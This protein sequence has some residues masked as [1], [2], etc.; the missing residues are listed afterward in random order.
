MTDLLRQ[1]AYARPGSDSRREAQCQFDDL[2]LY[3]WN[4]RKPDHVFRLGQD[5]DL[6]QARQLMPA[7]QNRSPEMLKDHVVRCLVF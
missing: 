2:I 5:L 4:M 6:H 1:A 3:S 7:E